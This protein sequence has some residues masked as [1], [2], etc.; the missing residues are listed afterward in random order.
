MALE[1][2]AIRSFIGIA[3]RKDLSKKA[4]GHS[5]Q[6]TAHRNDLN[7][8]DGRF[9]SANLDGSSPK[10]G[11]SCHTEAIISQNT[12]FCDHWHDSISKLKVHQ[13]QS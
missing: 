9:S 13:F 6:L 10:T 7:E 4:R 11:R 12:L 2:R 8:V 1:L 5:R 3:V